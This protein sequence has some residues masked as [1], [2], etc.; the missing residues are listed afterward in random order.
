MNSALKFLCCLSVFALALS[1][2]SSFEAKGDAAYR[3]SQMAMGGQKEL[4]LKEA[5][6]NYNEAIKA[7]GNRAGIQLRQRF[8]EMT[9][10]RAKKMISEGSYARDDVRLFL[11]D[12]DKNM[13]DGIPEVVKNRYGEILVQIADSF[14]VHENMDSALVYINK[15]ASYSTDPQEI[16]TKRELMVKGFADSHFELA[17]NNFEDGVK[18]KDEQEAS[19]CYVLA[20]YYALLTLLYYPDYPGGQELL[21]KIREKNKGVFSAYKSVLDGEPNVQVNK[22]DIFLRVSSDR[23]ATKEIGM[24]NYS[25]NPLRIQAGDFALVDAEGNTYP[26]VSAA[27]MKK[28]ILDQDHQADYTITF[29]QPQGKVKKVVYQNGDHYTEKVLF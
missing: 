21:G 2:T 28:E 11:R 4:L 9:V 24:F 27:P 18:A 5:Y 7:K 3:R 23:G 22:Y 6:I 14:Y 1:C 15:A 17:K 13:Y 8:V 10:V 16:T 25:Y 26:G 12:I 19:G 20:E 29:K